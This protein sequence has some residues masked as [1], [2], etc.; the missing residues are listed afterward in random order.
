MALLEI[1]VIP[2]GTQTASFS[3]YVSNA[4]QLIEQKGLNY[5]VTPTS[6]VI[7]GNLQE[8]MSVAQQIHQHAFTNGCQRVITNIS[9]DERNDKNMSLNQQVQSIKPS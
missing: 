4:I 3:S 8:L 9:I 6:T 1:S 5:Q 2:V 7:E